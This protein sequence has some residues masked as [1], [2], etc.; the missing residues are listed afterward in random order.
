LWEQ[1]D[2]KGIFSHKFDVEWKLL[3]GVSAH[4]R[5]NQSSSPKNDANTAKAPSPSAAETEEEAFFYL[6]DE[7]R[8]K[9]VFHWWDASFKTPLFP[10]VQILDYRQR[11]DE[12]V[13]DT[14]RNKVVDAFHRALKVLLLYHHAD[15]TDTRAR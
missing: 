2:R 15:R 1:A 11:Y 3:E 7:V 14:V 5:E 13:S 4:S 9:P 12:L 10:F 8:R 6:R